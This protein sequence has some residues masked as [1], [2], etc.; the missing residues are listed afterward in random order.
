METETFIS[1]TKRIVPSWVEKEHRTAYCFWKS[2][3]TQN[4]KRKSSQN[5]T[6]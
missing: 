6:D 3:M 4:Q 1:E 5:R 2:L